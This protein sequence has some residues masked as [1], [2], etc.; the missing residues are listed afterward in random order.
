MRV[1]ER[2]GAA[3]EAARAR[4]PRGAH[5]VASGGGDLGAAWNGGG[6][7]KAWRWQGWRAP[8]PAVVGCL[9]TLTL[10][11]L[12][13]GG[14]GRGILS[15]FSPLETTEF[16]QKPGNHA[17]S[18]FRHALG[19]AQINDIKISLSGEFHG[20]VSKTTR[21]CKIKRNLDKTLTLMTS[22]SE[23]KPDGA[24]FS[25]MKPSFSKKMSRNFLFEGH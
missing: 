12:V 2:A 24:A 22:S 16:V 13:L 25:E 11:V 17:R 15:T 9:A 19:L 10:L 4:T 8:A 3:M 23:M 6:S 1:Q 20:V 7:Y 14:G 21:S 5:K 18:Q